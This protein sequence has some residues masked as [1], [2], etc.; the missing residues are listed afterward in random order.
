MSSDLNY[1]AALVQAV[2]LT[3]YTYRDVAPLSVGDKPVDQD[4]II[5]IW[6]LIGLLA[7]TGVI[8]PGFMPVYS[9]SGVEKEVRVWVSETRPSYIHAAT[10]RPQS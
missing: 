6:P 8:A 9:N 3:V 7:Y 5:L 1:H 4:I 10:G 2:T